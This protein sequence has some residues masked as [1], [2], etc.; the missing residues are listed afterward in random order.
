M[1]RIRTIKPQFFTSEDVTALEPLARLLFVGLFTECDRD[2]RVED[3]PRTLKMRLLPE[4]DVDLDALLWSLVDGGLIRRYE[5]NGVHIIQ[6]SGFLK[7]QKPHPK[8]PA[9]IL[10]D[11]GTDRPKPCKKTASREEVVILP[12]ENP[13]SPVGREG[14]E[15]GV[16]LREGEREPEKGRAPVQGS[17]AFEPG[18]LPRD[19]M[20]HSI[21]GPAF[22]IC[23]LTW[24]FDTLAKAYNAPENPH[25]TRAVIAQ[26]IEQLETGLSPDAS[27]GPFSWVEREFHTYLKSVGRVPPKLSTKPEPFSIQKVLDKKAAE[28]AAKG[29]AS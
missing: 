2:G 23:L 8:E 19:H 29:K 25:G 15:Y 7:H 17:G 12:V 26:F 21:C 5:A 11:Q 13:S 14:K 28:K 10:P 18:S 6:V 16:S 22:K 9:S 3:R 4:D 27:I 1:A 24:Q 20:R